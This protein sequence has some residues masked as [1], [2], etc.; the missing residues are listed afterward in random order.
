MIAQLDRDYLRTSPRKAVT[1]L[2]SYGL[3]EGRP[4]T[5]RGAWI[6]PLL[7][8]QFR[9]L[10]R[11][12]QLKRVRAP[13]FILGTGRSGTTIL[14]KVLSLHPHLGF[15]NE[16][17]ALWHAV[18]PG[19]DLIGSYGLGA[20]RYRLGPAD[21]D[22]EVVGAAHRLYGAYLALSGSRRVLDKYP[23]MIFRTGFLDTIFPDAHY[24]LLTRNGLDTL[25]SIEGWS[26]RH[27]ARVQGEVH[28]WWGRDGRKWRL[29]CEQI[30]PDEPL[31]ADLAPEI[32]GL[33]RHQDRAAVEWIA[34]MQ[35]G[36]RL[37]R[38][39]PER[40]HLVRYEALVERPREVLAELF[41]RCDLP[42]DEA[43]LAYAERTLAPSAP[44]R[45]AVLAPAIR[46][47]FEQTMT[48]LGYG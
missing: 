10:R 38:E 33:E 13:L 22:T 24:L 16:P 15:L 36:K 20:A 41:A 18:H 23:E 48:Q 25:Q 28:D 44:K 26:R 19:E 14:G 5:T 45:G 30:V 42:S 1:R 29:L 35:Q 7:Q 39:R 12:P 37:L 43:T 8:A 21:A 4:L 17:K 3:F 27:G 46:P 2:L 31:L 40:S 32:A 9:L 6:N 11:L 47:A 34:V